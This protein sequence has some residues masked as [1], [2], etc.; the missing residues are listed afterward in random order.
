M[1]A[2]TDAH[3]RYNLAYFQVDVSS[4]ECSCFKV[5]SPRLP[6]DADATD[7][8]KNYATKN[9]AYSSWSCT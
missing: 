8:I 7:W 5:H 6:S 4:G 2:A 3:D 9:N 1:R